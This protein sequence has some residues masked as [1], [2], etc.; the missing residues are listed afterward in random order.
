MD[1]WLSIKDIFAIAKYQEIENQYIKM[2]ESNGTGN[3]FQVLIGEIVIVSIAHC[4]T[5]NKYFIICKKKK[6][7]PIIAM[8]SDDKMKWIAM[9]CSK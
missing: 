5:L 6:S 3:R 2:I 4:L 9:K 7:I 8:Y 1:G